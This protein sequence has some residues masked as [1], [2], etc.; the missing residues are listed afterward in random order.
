MTNDRILVIV[1]MQAQQLLQ[2]MCRQHSDTN[3]LQN[4]D[5]K[6]EAS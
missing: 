6:L 2:T 1:L 4:S 3:G 5:S